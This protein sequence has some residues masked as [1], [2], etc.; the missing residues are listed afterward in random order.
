MDHVINDTETQPILL[1]PFVTIATT[2]VL[3]I[4]AMIL[5]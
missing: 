2:L 5:H 3:V 4:V 1:A